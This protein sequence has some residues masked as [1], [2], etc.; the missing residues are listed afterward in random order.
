MGSGEANGDG[1][2]VPHPGSVLVGITHRPMYFVAS[3]KVPEGASEA[4]L[5]VQTGLL[6][7]EWLAPQKCPAVQVQ[8]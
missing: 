7:G 1:D 5:W 2:V 8:L 6:N 4:T 3:M